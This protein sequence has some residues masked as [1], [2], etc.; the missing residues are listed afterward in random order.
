[1]SDLLVLWDARSGN[2]CLQKFIEDFAVELERFSL[3]VRIVALSVSTSLNE[4][5]I[6][7]SMRAL[8]DLVHIESPLHL[9]TFGEKAN[10][11]AALISPALKCELHT[12]RLPAWL[13]ESSSSSALSKIAKFI[14]KNEIWGDGKELKD[15]FYPRYTSKASSSIF[16][17]KEDALADAIGEHAQANGIDY[18][19]VS[20]GD[21]LSPSRLLIEEG[22]LLVVSSK[23]MASGEVV[24]LANGY[25]LP[26]LL[27]S[28]EARNY[29]IREGENGW[30]VS[31]MQQI[32]YTN[33]LINW[34]GMSQNAREMISRYCQM[35]QSA[36]SGLRC[37]SASLGYPERLELKEFKLRG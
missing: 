36:Q 37:Y 26:V 13:E 23:F 18:R 28:Q 30:V 8:L 10:S 3:T 17:F 27:I 35:S 7:P 4:N 31:T 22:G 14:H 20:Y 1:M 6:K 21:F 33:C 5:Q 24:E 9:I 25:G 2:A 15:Y 16:F 32:Q 12:N 29:G 11:L 34:Q 19:S